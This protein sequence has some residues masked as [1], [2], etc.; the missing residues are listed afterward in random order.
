MNRAALHM[1]AC[2]TL[3][4]ASMAQAPKMGGEMSH[5]LVSLYQQQIY[6]SLE[7][8]DELPLTMHNYQERYSGNAG[9]L[10]RSG[11]NAQ[12]GWLANGFI[13]LPSD[14]AMWIE[15]LDQT[16]GLRAFEQGTFAPIF[17]TAGS[18]TLWEWGGSMV[19]NWYSAFAIGDYEATY[20]VFV[21]AL[22]GSHYPGYT[23]GQ[24]TLGWT[25]PTGG[26]GSTGGMYTD[27]RSTQQIPAPGAS[28]VLAAAGVL[29]VRRRR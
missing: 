21:G 17:G 4:G 12:F 2:G 3:A 23:G 11:Y 5:V 26:L 15:P 22:D 16:P 14:A 28:L 25:Y 10:D 19:H 6:I 8:P 13:S 1:L 7:R 24:I 27:V 18:S 9:V 20:R 29:G